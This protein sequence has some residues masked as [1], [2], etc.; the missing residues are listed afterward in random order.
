[1]AIS[2]E[3]HTEI[4]VALYAPSLSCLFFSSVMV[5]I[6]CLCKA[7]KKLKG[8][9]MPSQWDLMTRRWLQED[10]GRGRGTQEIPGVSSNAFVAAPAFVMLLWI[11]ILWPLCLWLWNGLELL[12]RLYL[13]FG[14][15]C[16]L[17]RC[18]G[19]PCVDGS[20]NTHQCWWSEKQSWSWCHCKP[21]HLPQTSFQHIFPLQHLRQLFGKL[22]TGEIIGVLPLGLTKQGPLHQEENEDGGVRVLGGFTEVVFAVFRSKLS[23]K[24]DIIFTHQFCWTLI[25]DLFLV[26]S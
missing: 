12:V 13:A 1:M 20:Q 7:A 25:M 2:R 10:G 18:L 11:R 22:G 14:N 21:T 3:S 4:A 8:E 17:S 24:L 5:V 9:G 6:R 26:I 23:S 19:W 16:S 15:S